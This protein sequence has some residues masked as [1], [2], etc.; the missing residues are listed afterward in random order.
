[1]LSGFLAGITEPAI[2]G[3]NLPLKKPFYFGIAGGV[4][5]GAIAAAG[6]SGATAFVFPSLLGLPAFSQVGNFGLQLLGTG[7][8]VVVAFTLTFFFGPREEAVAAAP[9][10]GTPVPEAVSGAPASASSGPT[11][12]AATAAGTVD[13]VAPVA[14]RAVALADVQDKVFAS[15]AMGRGLG[16]I[17]ADGHIYSPITGTIKAAM[18]TGHAFGIKSEDG[19]EVLVHIGIDTVQLQGRGFEAAVTRGQQVRAGDLLAVVDLALVAEAG[20][21][22]TTLV[23]V[24]NTAQLGSVDPVDGGTLAQGDTAITVRL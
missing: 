1:A 7:A 21:D 2:Y 4:I 12:A 3:V 10:A 20:H 5:G 19:V 8:A 11:T 14:G 17:P 23:M 6:G 13:I 22:T 24:T 18:K 15:G 16:I 9:D